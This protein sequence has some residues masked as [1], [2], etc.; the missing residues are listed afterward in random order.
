M[1]R[2]LKTGFTT[3]RARRV[4][5]DAFPAAPGP[6]EDPQ[7]A[8]QVA[9]A[10]AEFLACRNLGTAAAP[11]GTIARSGPAQDPPWAAEP[12]APRAGQRVAQDSGLLVREVAIQAM[13][14]LAGARTGETSQHLHRV[15]HHVRMLG[16]RLQVHP[17][18]RSFL[19]DAI[20]EELYR[21]APLHDL[22]KLAVPERIL[23]KPGP[24]TAEERRV[25]R[26][27][28]TLG[29][30]AIEVAELRLGVPPETLVVAKVM[31]E[32]H[33]E[34]WDGSGYPW[35]LAG[36]AIPIPARIMAVADVYDVLTSRCPYKAALGHPEALR[37]MQQ[38]RGSQFDPDVLDAFLQISEAFHAVSTRF[39]DPA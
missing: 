18:F 27:H 24:L 6:C 37:I 5:T 2:Y 36:E 20:V 14:A 25:V 4:P 21:S 10:R 9:Q 8:G 19:A 32:G 39:P 35:G 30:E 12:E 17:R 33:H 3:G 7:L 16:R 34:R 22:G 11:P 26:R 1:I 28:P 15:Q 29:R 23:Q 38:G 13:A 31:A